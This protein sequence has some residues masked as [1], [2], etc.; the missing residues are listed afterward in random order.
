MQRDGSGDGAG[1]KVG[2]S[3]WREARVALCLVLMFLILRRVV[4]VGLLAQ[5]LNRVLHS[6]IILLSWWYANVPESDPKWPE[7]E[8]AHVA[9]WRICLST[10]WCRLLT[11]ALALSLLLSDSTLLRIPSKHCSQCLSVLEVL[12][13]RVGLVVAL[14]SLCRRR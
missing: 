9:C 14:R 1:G 3:P 12:L 7:V 5:S 10:L 8:H 2:S 11:L 13:A 6:N 4:S